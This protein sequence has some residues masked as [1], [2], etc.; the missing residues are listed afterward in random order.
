VVVVTGSDVRDLDEG[1]FA[2]VLCKPVHPEMIVHAIENCLRSG[3]RP[4]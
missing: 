4:I 2:C 1:D 3:P